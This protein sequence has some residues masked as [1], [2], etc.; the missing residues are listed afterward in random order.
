MRRQ[1]APRIVFGRRQHAVDD[2]HFGHGERAVHG[3]QRAQQRI[4]ARRLAA[5]G[6]S[7]PGIHGLQVAIDLGVENLEQQGVELGGYRSQSLAGFGQVDRRRRF[8]HRLLDGRFRRG[9]GRGRPERGDFGRHRLVASRNAVGRVLENG[10][11]GGQC[12]LAAQRR[13]QFGEGVEGAVD[14]RHDRRARGA[15]AVAHLVEHVLDL[16]AELAQLARANQASAALEGVEHAAHRRQP[17][18]AARLGPPQ[19]Q[20]PV[21]VVDLL[22]ELFEEDLADLL[23]DLVAHAFEAADQRAGGCGRGRR[24]L[25]A[26]DDRLGLGRDHHFPGRNGGSDRLRR[27]HSRLRLPRRLRQRPVAQRLEAVAGDVEDLLAVAA[28]F[29]Q[30]FEVV[31]EAGQRIGKGVELAA[32]GHPLAR[33]QLVLGVAADRDQIVGGQRQFHHPQ[34]AGHLVQQP[35]HFRQLLVLPAGFDEGHQRLAGLDEVGD[36]LAHDRVHDLAGFACEQLVLGTGAGIGGAEPGDLVVERG[37][38][39]EQRASDVQ[40]RVLVGGNGAVENRVHRV[41]LLLHHLARDA[42]AQHPQGVGDATERLGMRLQRGKIVRTGAQVQVE[43]V[44]DVQQVV[45]HR[46]GHGVEQRTVAAAD[47]AARVLELRLGR[48]G[49][50]EFEHPLEFLQRRMA[51]V[52]AV[53][54]VEQQLAGRLV[55]RLAA[56]FGKAVVVLQAVARLALDPG[57][58]LAQSGRGRQRAVGDRAGHVRGHPQHAPHRHLPHVRQQCVDR[59]R[60]RRERGAGTILLPAAE[61]ALQ[62]LEQRLGVVVGRSGKA[63]CDRAG[64]RSFQ[65]RREQHALAEP[66]LAARGAQLVE[67]RQQHDRNVAMPALQAFEIVGEQDDAAQQRGAGRVAVADA[68]G[69]ERQRHLLHFLGHHRRRIQLDHAQRALHLVQVAGAQPHPADVGLVLD[70]ILEFGLGQAQG[71]VELGLDPAERGVLERFAQRGHRSPPRVPACVR[72]RRVVV[73][74]IQ[75]TRPVLRPAA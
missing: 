17:V 69:M 7:H 47:A 5:A 11:I 67:Q 3:V 61:R 54:D 37:V 21:E 48:H 58:H 63:A 53:G 50:V 55:R 32:V 27:H 8:L 35:R 71:L 36:R 52:V 72:V 22:G 2:R 23:V 16:P 30:R 46:R 26:F 25:H 43:R 12:G 34:R 51:A 45:L 28:L 70:V 9:F 49:R 40:Q 60:Q 59:R 57:K 24:R 73:A 19:R 14:H 29:A 20:Q 39:V 41:A 1:Q 66:A 4:A 38:D 42:Q 33:D 74:F 64:Q 6:R 56:C 15:L 44:L 65:I 68:A 31:L 62:R 13:Q 10:Q 18:E 75:S